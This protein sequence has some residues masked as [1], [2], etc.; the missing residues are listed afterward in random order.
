MKQCIKCARLLALDEFYRHPQMGDGH[1]NACKDC[2]RRDV[3]A[4]RR[5]NLEYYRGYDRKRFKE[6]PDRR[7]AAFAS[8]HQSR[9]AHPEKYRA[10]TAVNNALRDGR[11]IRHPCEVCGSA[12]SEAHHD[13]Y[14]KPLEVRWLCVVDHADYHRQQ[15]EVA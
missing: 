13:D 15:R 4:N 2:V 5:G 7:A 10:R 8:S 11:L 14:S 6:D 3:K 9:R 12:K 1:L